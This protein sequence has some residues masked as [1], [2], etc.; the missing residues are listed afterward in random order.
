MSVV[1]R[2]VVAQASRFTGRF[3]LQQLVQLADL[4]LQQIDLPLLAKRRSIEFFKMVFA[5][6]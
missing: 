2:D 6:T 5:E 1:R 4:C 3:R